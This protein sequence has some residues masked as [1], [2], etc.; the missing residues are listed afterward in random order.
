MTKDNILS[1]LIIDSYKIMFHRH[2]IEDWINVHVT[3][4]SQWNKH[5]VYNVQSINKVVFNAKENF[6]VSFLHHIWVC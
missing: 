3:I 6:K 2:R 1:N 5:F 4:A